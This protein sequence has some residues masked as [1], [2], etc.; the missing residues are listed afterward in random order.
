MRVEFAAAVR[1]RAAA[2]SSTLQAS[3]EVPEPG[4]DPVG[5]LPHLVDAAQ[6]LVELGPVDEIAAFLLQIF[7]NVLAGGAPRAA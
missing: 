3:L 4:L 2:S 6:E 7:G 1:G 5:G